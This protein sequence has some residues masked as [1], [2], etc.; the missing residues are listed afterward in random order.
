MADVNE[1]HLA[2]VINRLNRR[3]RLEAVPAEQFPLS[4]AQTR[5]LDVMPAEGCRIV[6]LSGELRVSSQGLGQLVTHL[7]REGYVEL[8]P[9]PADRRAKLIRRTPLG[10]SVVEQVRE[11]LDGVERSWRE[12]IGARRY[13]TFRQVLNELAEG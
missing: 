3:L 6:D 1:P 8:T 11:L 13:D 9:D 10:D 2:L 12:E 5:I 7:A 4:V